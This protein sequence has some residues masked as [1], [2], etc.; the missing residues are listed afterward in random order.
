M[1][2]QIV[3][4]ENLRFDSHEEA[5]RFYCNYAKMARHGVHIIKTHP[6]VGEF[7]YNKQGKWEFYK[8]EE[9]RKEEKTYCKAFVK[10]KLNKK[11]GYWYFERIKMEHKHILTPNEETVKFM[12]AHK[13][14]DPIIMHMVDQW[15]R[16]NVPINCTVNLLS[17]I[18]G[19]RQ[20]L[21]FT[22]T[23]LKNR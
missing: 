3:S 10:V 12:N 16:N 18:Y 20:N 22:E 14:K 15:H 7:N 19:G 13:N 1:P 6:E 21:S 2:A 23:D 4:N 17:D 5:Y 8:P 11:K 9:E